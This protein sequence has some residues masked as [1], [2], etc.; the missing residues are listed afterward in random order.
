MA[1]A[2]GGFDWLEVVYRL[3]SRAGPVFHF[4]AFL[5]I[6][7]FYVLAR[8]FQ[9]FRECRLETRRL[10]VNLRPRSFWQASAISPT[11]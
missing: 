6:V 3:S 1:V 8:C 9:A 7:M 2:L 4:A 11:P 10:R 5:S